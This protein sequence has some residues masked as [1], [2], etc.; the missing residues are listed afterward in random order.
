MLSNEDRGK[1][2]LF[3]LLKIGDCMYDL[4]LKLKLSFSPS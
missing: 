3:C 4:H 1:V 2:V